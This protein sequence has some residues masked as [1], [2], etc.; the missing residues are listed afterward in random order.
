MHH[1]VVEIGG[2]EV[3]PGAQLEGIE[4]GVD[5]GI[6]EGVGVGRDYMLGMIPIVGQQGGSVRSP[7]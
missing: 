7:P 6:G 5:P 2:T 1:R 3:D 4:I